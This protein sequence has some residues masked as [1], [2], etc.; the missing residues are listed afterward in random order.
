MR[1]Q[2][3]VAEAPV[4]SVTRNWKNS[5]P[6]DPAFPFNLP[7]P[8][9]VKPDGNVPRIDQLYGAVPPVAVICCEYGW[10][11]VAEGSGHAVVMLMAG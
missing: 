8:L 1:L 10:P 7:S 6:A 11:V 4:L 9:S 3:F 5:G 2:P